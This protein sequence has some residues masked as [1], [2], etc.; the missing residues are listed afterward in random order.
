ML[1]VRHYSPAILR[2]MPDTQ[3]YSHHLLILAYKLFIRLYYKLTRTALMLGLPTRLPLLLQL[4]LQLLILLRL[5]PRKID[6]TLTTL[7]GVIKLSIVG[8]EVTAF[9]TVSIAAPRTEQLVREP[10]ILLIL[11]NYGRNITHG[12]N[13]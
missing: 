4:R 2:A 8:V 9:A 1:P 13:L 7:A 5:P 3:C 6:I 10:V 11:F 12:L